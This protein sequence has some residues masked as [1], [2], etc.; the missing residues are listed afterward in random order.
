MKKPPSARQLK[1][2]DLIKKEI[3]RVLIEEMSELALGRITI[4][5]VELSRDFSFARVYISALDEARLPDIVSTLKTVRAE[6]RYH[7]AQSLQL[8]KTPE[9]RFEIDSAI[10]QGDKLVQLIDEQSRRLD[11]HN[12]SN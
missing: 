1:M 3:A 9:L 8:R 6:F 5:E 4:T 2:A 10:I 12:D 11:K 7:L